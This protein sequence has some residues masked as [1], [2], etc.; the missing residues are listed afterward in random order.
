MRLSQG[1][2]E[3]EEEREGGGKSR[4]RARAAVMALETLSP[5]WE[6][7]RLDDGSQSE[8]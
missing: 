4:C 8:R 1:R 5:D 6:F 3:E 7:D 2:E